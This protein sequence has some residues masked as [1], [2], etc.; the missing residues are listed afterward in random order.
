MGASDICL[1]TGITL[2]DPS[3]SELVGQAGYD[4]TWIDAEHGSFDLPTIAAHIMAVRG[5]QTAPWCGSPVTTETSSN[6]CLI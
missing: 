6:R 5:T 1:A 2:S 3:V 4:F